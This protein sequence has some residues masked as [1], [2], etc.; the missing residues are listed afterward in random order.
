VTALPGA[1]IDPEANASDPSLRV[2]A[3]LALA[4]AIAPFATDMYLPA[5]PRIAREF[6]VSTSVVQLT[7]TGFLLG[8]GLGQL[9]IGPLSDTTGRRRPLLVASG[10]CILASILCALAPTIG[11]LIIARFVQGFS[12]AAGAV[13]SRAVITDRTSGTTTARYFSL[14][15][16]I[17][18][19]APIIAPITGAGLLGP[20]GW[21]GILWVVAAISVVMFA[22]L[23]TSIPESLPPE[24]RHSGG[25]RAFALK[26]RGV[27]G[28][29]RFT[30]YA[31]T[32]AFA[33]M[34]MF[35]WIS[36]SP[37]VL[38]NK[39]G[40]A[41][42]WYALAFAS[43]A[44]AYLTANAVNVKIV[45][46]YGQRL[47]IKYGLSGLVVASLGMGVNVG[48]GTHVWPTVVLAFMTLASMGFVLGNC[49]ALAIEQV[50]HSAGTGS[51]VLG[52][53]QFGLGALVAPLVGLAGSHSAVPL[54]VSMIVTT[55]LAAMIFTAVGRG[56]RP[57]SP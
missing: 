51:A 16:V 46:R 8:V 6:D 36:A 20:I 30:G 27:L 33:F 52:A 4:S 21:R 7:L 23:A 29:R 13:L 38:Q 22:G 3:V 12:G 47:L 14:M 44:V 55:A 17:S 39:L 25:V 45:R 10:I 41:T 32:F 37:F 43:N 31:A 50:R 34:T 42:G 40:L 26:A 49:A 11:L 1:R 18:G 2:V 19:V 5:L 57:A 48:L 54:A 56:R 53:S 28:N 9:I 15:M 24:L 35:G